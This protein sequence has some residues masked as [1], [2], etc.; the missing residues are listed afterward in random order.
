LQNSLITNQN[1]RNPA[2]NQFA[3]NQN[4]PKKQLL[5]MAGYGSSGK[6]RI[7]YDTE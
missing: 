2:S 3:K 5:A 7:R 6:R 1:P 4:P